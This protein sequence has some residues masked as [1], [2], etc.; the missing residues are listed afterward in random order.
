MEDANPLSSEEANHVERMII[1]DGELFAVPTE[2]ATEEQVNDSLNNMLTQFYVPSTDEKGSFGVPNLGTIGEH[3][4]KL[5]ELNADLFDVPVI[6]AN[7][8]FGAMNEY[9]ANDEYEMLMLMGNNKEDENEAIENEL[10][11]AIDQLIAECA[12]DFGLIGKKGGGNGNDGGDSSS[13]SFE[14]LTLE[15]KSPSVINISSD[16]IVMMLNP[17]K[18][19]SCWEIE[20]FK[21][22]EP[23]E[24][25]G[26]GRWDPMLLEQELNHE[27]LMN[28]LKLDE[29]RSKEKMVDKEGEDERRKGKRTTEVGI[30]SEKSKA[31]RI[32]GVNLHPL[33]IGYGINS[34]VKPRIRATAR[35]SVRRKL[36]TPAKRPWEIC[37]YT[38]HSTEQCL[39]PPQAMPYMVD[40]A[41]CYSCGGVGHVS[42]YCPY[43]APNAGEGSSR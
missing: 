34:K 16:N 20:M 24:E 37:G 36:P 21:G 31:Q 27:Y 22:D 25:E 9:G 17:S 19:E 3:G 13:D 26:R 43:L 41:K 29:E 10:E 23:S 18:P 6:H 5:E 12:Q 32:V 39:H 2:N 14:S 15:P 35:K 30:E 11:H 40:C 42:M 7:G 1:E 4:L 38:D 28:H 8:A 33:R